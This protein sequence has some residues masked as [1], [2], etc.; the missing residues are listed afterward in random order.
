MKNYKLKIFI[1]LKYTLLSVIMIF[2]LFPFAWLFITSLKSSDEIFSQVPSWIVKKIEW[3]NYTWIL[4][5]SGGNLL[6]YLMNSFIVTFT[7]MILTMVLAISSGYSIGRY[8][9]RGKKIFMG[10][11]FLTQ[12]FQGPLIMIPW[13]KM[14]SFLRI[15]D[16]KLVLILIYGTITVPLATIMMSGFFRTIPNEV[17]EAAYIDGSSAFKTLVQIETP[18]ILPGM[19]SVSILSFILAWNDYQYALILTS[20]PKAK[21]VQILIN[22][23][24]SAIGNMNWGGLMAGGVLVTVPVIIMFGIAQRYMID[25]LT[26]GAVKG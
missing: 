25:G 14:S 22:E 13:Y 18:L 26:A 9:F 2:I 3:S 20:S 10:L 6:H 23:M 24:I 5:P 16:T 21:T 8:S 12:L 7:S 19:V 15:V 4:K 17:R 1:I 11:I